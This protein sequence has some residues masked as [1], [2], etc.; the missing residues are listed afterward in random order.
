MVDLEGGKDVL[1]EI[2]GGEKG[3]G[4]GKNGLCSLW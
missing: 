4:E 1:R 3:G 2:F